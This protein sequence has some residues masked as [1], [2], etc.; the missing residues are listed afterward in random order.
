MES[1]FDVNDMNYMVF[2]ILS[3]ENNKIGMD[4][5]MFTSYLT[6]LRK[7]PYKY[8]KKE[9]KEYVHEDITYEN[10]CNNDIKV[11]SKYP[12]LA[13][14]LNDNILGILYTKTKL[15]ILSFPSS[16]KINTINYVKKLSFRVNNRIY[17]NF[18]IK[19]NSLEEKTYAIYVNYNHD[20]NVD[21]SE[22]IKLIRQVFDLLK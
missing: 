5:K 11:Y 1:L 13:K 21:K 22:H 14:T 7:T 15:T 20:I 3:G 4:F 6:R 2:Y 17:I 12:I 18:E 9:Y 10:D 19:L 8:L 16:L